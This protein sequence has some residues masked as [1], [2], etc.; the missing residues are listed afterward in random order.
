MQHLGCWFQSCFDSEHS[1]TNHSDKLS[2]RITVE[3]LNLSV[4]LPTHYTQLLF[5]FSL[6]SL[7]RFSLTSSEFAQAHQPSPPSVVHFQLP[8]ETWPSIHWPDS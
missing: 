6:A 1:E 7:V 5:A 2:Q 4:C 3:L 8:F